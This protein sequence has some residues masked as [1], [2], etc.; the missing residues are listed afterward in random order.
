MQ[1]TS[2]AQANAIK[3][4]WR[5]VGQTFPPAVLNGPNQLFEERLR[6]T[7]DRVRILNTT[8]ALMVAPTGI[9]PAN[10]VP[11]APIDYPIVLPCTGFRV[12]E[13]LLLPANPDEFYVIC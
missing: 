3:M 11:A 5:I 9:E 8:R 10:R 4:A 1:P 13:S 2:V 7:A 6:R 12:F